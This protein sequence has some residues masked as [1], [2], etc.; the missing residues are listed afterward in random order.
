[1]NLKIIYNKYLKTNHNIILYIKHK[2]STSSGSSVRIL[3]RVK[4]FDNRKG[5]GF[6]NNLTTSGEV[7]VH[8]SGLKSSNGVFRTLYP[9]EYIEF[10]LHRDDAN[11]RDYAV[12][13]TGV[14]GGSLLCE[15]TDTRLMVRRAR[16]N[17]DS[18]GGGEF[19]R[20]EAR[21]SRPQRGGRAPRNVD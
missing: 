6:V 12:D 13:V 7:F 18:D 14:K 11:N 20:V 21:G 2:M 3:G 8:H 16:P 19:K 10:S 17:Q 5:F 4:W 1:M 15:N 9:G